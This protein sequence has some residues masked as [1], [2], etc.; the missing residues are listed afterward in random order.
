MGNTAV[1]A[2]ILTYYPEP[3]EP[4]PYNVLRA[5]R[6]THDTY[7]IE[8][9][10]TNGASAQPFAPG[11]FNM[12]YAFGI[13]EV[14]ISISGGDST[15]LGTLLH[16]VRAVGTVTGA[17]CRLRK[18]DVIGLRG[19]FGSH[20]P[21]DEAEGNDVVIVAGGLG[22]A[23]LRSAIY[24]LQ[25]H[26]GRYGR[27][28]IVYGARNPSDILY[29]RELHQWRSRF[30]M[31]V[32]VTVD[33]ATPTWHGDVGV[34]TRLISK[35]TFDPINTVAFVCGPEIMMRFATMELQ[36]SGLDPQQIYVSME[37]NMKC[38]VGFCGH[39]QYGPIF[40]CKDGPVFPYERVMR[41]MGIREV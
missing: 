2:K 38:A 21:V 24:H 7:T 25:A 37:R 41:L 9:T 32:L 11:Q 16:T 34:V 30:D 8:V 6:E 33:Y 13:G 4:L 18:G 27:L 19:P 31:D 15:G 26:R 17:L 3:M 5:R 23:P 28:V 29:R 1:Q 36:Q 40:I 10:P 12:L 22:L 20:W 14:P 39:C 35:A